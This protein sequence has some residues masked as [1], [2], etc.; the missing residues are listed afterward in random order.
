MKD[1]VIVVTV[2]RDAAMYDLCVGK[3]RLLRTCA[4]AAVDNNAENL[5]LA[6]RYNAFLDAYDYSRPAWLVFCHED[7]EMKEDFSFLDGLDRNVIWGPIGAATVRRR[8]WLFGGAWCNRIVGSVEECGKSGAGA[9]TF[10]NPCAK[11]TEVDTLD[12]MCLIVHSSLVRKFSLRFDPC[13]T[14]DLYAE[15]FCIA[16]RE[17]HGVRSM[18]APMKCLHRS[19]GSITARFH[20]Q[21]GRLDRKY[22][23]T[24]RFSTTGYGIGGGATAMRR[25]QKRF[26]RF[27]DRRCPW[28][29]KA[30]LRIFAGGAG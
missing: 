6:V 25:V 11:G 4:F 14:F 24:E 3:N 20:S 12:C 1:D 29:A 27:C 15:D 22:P 18:V 7:F 28:L 17:M 19:K 26:R 9:R 13:L 10:G 23:R 21:L 16:A 8:P 30:L 2:F 5:G